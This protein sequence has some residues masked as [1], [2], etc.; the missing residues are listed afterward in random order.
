GWAKGGPGWVGAGA[1]GVLGGG[2][3]GGGCRQGGSGGGGI[4]PRRKADGQ[5]CWQTDFSPHCGPRAAKAVSLHASRRAG[6]DR[7]PSRGGEIRRARIERIPRLGVLERGA[8]LFSDRAAQPF[9]GGVQLVLGLHHFPAR[10]A[11]D[12]RRAR[13]QKIRSDRLTRG[14][15]SRS[16]AQAIASIGPATSTPFVAAPAATRRSTLSTP[17]PS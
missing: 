16:T 7:P 17:F 9:R 5:V 10:C 8:H 12:H 14:C 13:R 6:D 3:W 15:A 2:G 11:P 4:R 1:A